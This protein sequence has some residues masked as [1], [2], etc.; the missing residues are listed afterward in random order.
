MFYFNGG[1]GDQLLLGTVARE[2]ARRG[3]Q[4]IWLLTQHPEF[5]R[6]NPDVQA[7]MP[8]DIWTM[9]W[10]RLSRIRVETILYADLDG[11]NDRDYPVHEH[12]LAS[13][14]RRAGITGEIA[15]RPHLP[16]VKPRQGGRRNRPLIAVQSGCLSARYPIPTK[17]W[18]PERMQAVVAALQDCAD[19][20]HLGAAGDPAMPGAS[21]LRGKLTLRES[22][23]KLADCDLFVGLVGFLMHLARAVECPSV[24]VYGGREPPE[25]TGYPCNVNLA[26]APACSPCW[27]Y[28]R[29]DYGRRCLTDIS[30]DH[31]VA[32]V[33]SAVAAPPARPLLTQRVTLVP[34]ELA[35][36]A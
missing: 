25:I 26:S 9:P 12:I 35:R 32:A 17:Q 5:F 28:R 10:F 13:L 20:V 4:K 1:A 30:V 6:D 3:K 15:L 31:V 19:F 7:A 16:G 22:A 21:D 34:G 18:P 11:D 14:C 33:R 27:H 2:L 24:I 29:C 36:S 8:Y 23:A